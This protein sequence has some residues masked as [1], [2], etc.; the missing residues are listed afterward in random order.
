MCQDV[1]EQETHIPETG[2][3]GTPRKTP[4]GRRLGIL[5][6]DLAATAKLER[7]L[8]TMDRISTQAAERGLTPEILEAELA[9]HKA[10][11]AH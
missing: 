7:L 11:R 8:T 9:A 2:K 1:F 4:R 10:G 3:S 6:R 5:S